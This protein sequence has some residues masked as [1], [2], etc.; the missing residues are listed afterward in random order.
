MVTKAGVPAS[1]IVVGMAFYGRSFQMTSPGCYGAD[2][3]YAGP[4]SGA[5]PGK[6]SNTSSYIS[7][8]EIRDIIATNSNVQQY[9]SDDGDILV[10]NNDM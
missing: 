4:E 9:S 7:N 1:K 6:C 3:T 5:S 10:Y 2:C 8:L